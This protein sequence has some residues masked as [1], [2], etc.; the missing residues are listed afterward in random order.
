MKINFTEEEKFK[1]NLFIQR[2]HSVNVEVDSLKK[3]AEDIKKRIEDEQLKLKEIKKE[4]DE[5]MNEL[6]K[7]YGKFSIQDVSNNI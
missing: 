2:Y 7:K 4:E 6:H 3:K 1:I 5:F